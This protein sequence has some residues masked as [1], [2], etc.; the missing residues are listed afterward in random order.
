VISRRGFTL[1]ELMIAM[2][3]SSLLVGMILAIFLRMSVAYR[4]QQQISDVQQVL[5]AARAMIEGDAKHAGLQTA[6]GVS[7]SLGVGSAVVQPVVVQNSSTAPDTVTFVYADTS[8]QAA[9]TVASI[10]GTLTVDDNSQ[11]PTT[12]L[13]IVSTPDTTTLVNP[14]DAS[15]AKLTTFTSCLL[16]MTGKTGTTSLTLSTAAPFGNLTQSFCTGIALN[17]TMVYRAVAVSYRINPDPTTGEGVLQRSVT[18]N[19][20]GLNDWEDLAYGFTDLQ[21]ATQFYETVATADATTD[22]TDPDTDVTRDWYSSTKQQ[23]ITTS[24]TESASHTPIQMTISLVART[25]KNFEGVTTAS[26]P[27]L[28]VTGNTANNTLGDRAAVDLTTTAD[29]LLTGTRVY[30]YTTFGVDFRNLGVGR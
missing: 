15:G 24:V 7:Y 2:V 27:L 20:Y 10:G 11:F 29:P 18:A 1:I 13:V 14:S 26:T 4:S 12:G 17:K 8:I 5:G 28:T 30:R 16:M 3:V 23:T 21:V 9:V 22:T 19:L 6:N 25:D